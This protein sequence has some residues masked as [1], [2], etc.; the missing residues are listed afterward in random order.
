MNGRLAKRM[1]REARLQAM[2]RDQQIFPE[3]KAFINNQ[4]FL[5]RLIIA[6]RILLRAF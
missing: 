4:R 6:W 3:L 1:R 2:N 5:D